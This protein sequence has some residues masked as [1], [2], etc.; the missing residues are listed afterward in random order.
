MCK[1]RSFLGINS[2]AH[3]MQNIPVGSISRCLEL[4]SLD[5]PN[6]FHCL[7]ECTLEGRIYKF[8]EHSTKR[9]RGMVAGN[10]DSMNR[11]SI[12]STKGRSSKWRMNYSYSS[13]AGNWD[14]S[15]SQRG[16]YPKDNQG[17][18]RGKLCYMKG[19]RV[20]MA[21]K[22]FGLSMYILCYKNFS[23]RGQNQI[24]HNNHKNLSKGCK[25]QPNR[26]CIWQYIADS[27]QGW[28]HKIC[29]SDHYILRKSYWAE[30]RQSH[31]LDKADHSDKRFGFLQPHFMW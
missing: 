21:S 18:W 7:S 30:L 17:R 8:V 23:H 25:C 22:L 27:T 29:S 16:K 11:W 19:I 14:K 1:N 12:N 28:N 5:S 26:E 31:I 6:N 4:C 2:I 15:Y 24:D 9:M 10:K 20:H 13:P 3:G